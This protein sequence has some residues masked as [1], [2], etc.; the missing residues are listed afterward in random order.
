MRRSVASFAVSILVVLTVV[1]AI[2]SFRTPDADGP[3]DKA[4][5][6]AILGE[7]HSE[8]DYADYEELA[9]QY[10]LNGT[11]FPPEGVAPT[12]RWADGPSGANSWLVLIKYA[13]GGAE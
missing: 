6:R 2:Y 13:D 5:I 7:Y 3:L 4:T 9:I 8:A 12:I 11:L 10:P 1:A